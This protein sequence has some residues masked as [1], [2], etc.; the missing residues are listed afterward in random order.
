GSS[1]FT[2]SKIR[3]SAAAWVAS[4]LCSLS[5]L[6]GATSLTNFAEIPAT[7]GPLYEL[8][9]SSSCLHS[10]VGLKSVSVKYMLTGSAVTPATGGSSGVPINS[11]SDTKACAYRSTSARGAVGEALEVTSPSGAAS[12]SSVPCP[13]HPTNTM[14]PAATRAAI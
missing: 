11:A 8:S 13:V 3:V 7:A 14:L 10:P 4:G 1:E 9:S 6:L 12:S 5:P 2:V